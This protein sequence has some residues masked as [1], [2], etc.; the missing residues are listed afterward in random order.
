[1]SLQIKYPADGNLLH[2]SD[3]PGC[4]HVAVDSY[5]PWVHCRSANPVRLA[6]LPRSLV[7]LVVNALPVLSMFFSEFFVR[8]GIPLLL[9]CGFST[10]ALV[11]SIIFNRIFAIYIPATTESN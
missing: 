6:H 9:G 1:M 4:C 2:C 10:L 5:S 11:N 3:T 8:L 7:I